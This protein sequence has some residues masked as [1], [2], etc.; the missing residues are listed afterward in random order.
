MIELIMD[1]KATE[2]R[3]AIKEDGKIF[4]LLIDRPTTH[5]I[6][7]NIYVG[8]VVNVLPGM[9]AAFVDFGQKKPGYLH[10]DHLC[11]YQTSTLSKAEKEQKGISHFVHQGEAIL[12]QVVKEGEGTKGAKLTGLLEFPGTHIVYQPYGKYKAISKRM[13]DVKRQEWRKLLQ[14]WLTSDEGVI[15]RTASEH[16]EA[17]LVEAEL[18]EL[19]RQFLEVQEKQS[20]S[21]KVPSLVHEEDHFLSKIIREIPPAEVKLV[22]VDHAG[23]SQFFKKKGYP[24]RF[25]QG[26]EGIFKRRGM[27]QE[28]EKALKRI[29]W[30]PSGGYI[31]IEHTEAMTVIDVNTGKYIGKTGLQETVLKTNLEAAVEIARQLRLRQ[32]GGIIIVDFIDMASDLERHQV[33]SQVKAGVQ[34]DRSHVRVIGFTELN[35]LQLTRK[36]VREPLTK[37]LLQPCSPCDGKGVVFSVD[38]VT[39]QLERELLEFKGSDVEA[40]V[41]EASPEVVDKLM[42]L[43]DIMERSGLQIYFIEKDGVPRF[44]IRFAGSVEDAKERVKTL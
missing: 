22:E 5:P 37:M 27:E 24:V 39:Y 17:D 4:E 32:I 40:L 30:L 33:L 34:K 31:I 14:E 8:R 13:S 23:T 11:S 42:G 38:T 21:V 29:V 25:Y 2:K 7:G 3:V 19:Q 1:M 15:L 16:V 28:L 36:K 20:A 35:L 26:K 18:L 9:Q 43:P 10:R 12:V 6:E 44:D 41:V